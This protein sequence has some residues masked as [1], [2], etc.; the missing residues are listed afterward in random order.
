[1][2]CRNTGA[3]TYRA[4][5]FD[6]WSSSKNASGAGV[7]FVGGNIVSNDGTVLLEGYSTEQWYH[8]RMTVNIQSG[9]YDVYIDAVQ[10]ASSLAAVANPRYIKL[11]GGNG[12]PGGTMEYDN[13]SFF[14]LSARGDAD[15]DRDVDG[16]DLTL[17][18]NTAVGCTC[19]CG[20]ADVTDETVMLSLDLNG[21]GVVD[22]LD[23]AICE[24]LLSDHLS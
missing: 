22:A 4:G 20:G 14:A 15:G 19:A 24:L 7:E 16:D 18:M 5:S 12:N 9:T 6:I 13:L 3:G 2:R 11:S 8:I 23:A 21:D 17:I 10:C 1:M